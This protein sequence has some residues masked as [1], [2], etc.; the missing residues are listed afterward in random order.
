MISLASRLS[1]PASFPRPLWAGAGGGVR[2]RE[3]AEESKPRSLSGARLLRAYRR[4]SPP[5]TPA[6]KGRGNLYMGACLRDYSAGGDYG[7]ASRWRL[8]SGGAVLRY[9]RRQGRNTWA[10]FY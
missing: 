10:R 6:H 1:M 9:A 8:V 3:R 2:A 5:P 4:Q 7:K